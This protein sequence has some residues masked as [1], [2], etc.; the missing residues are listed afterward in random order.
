MRKCAIAVLFVSSA[1][2]LGQDEA[3]LWAKYEKDVKPNQGSLSAREVISAW[4]RAESIRRRYSQKLQAVPG[5][6]I[7][8]RVRSRGSKSPDEDRGNHGQ[9]HWDQAEFL[10][11]NR[12][13]E[14]RSG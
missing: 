9:A 8:V 5:I 13:G 6:T 10:K 2:A 4:Q 12:A 3:D 14:G 1:S 11:K 7:T